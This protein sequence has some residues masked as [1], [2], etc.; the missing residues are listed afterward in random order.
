MKA[1]ERLHA[2]LQTQDG[3][4]KCLKRVIAR[5]KKTPRI[6]RFGGIPL[7]RQKKPAIKDP[8]RTPYVN[9]RSARVERLMKDTCEVC[10]SKAKVHMHHIR[11]LK[12]LHKEGKRELPLWMKIMIYRKRQSIPECM[13][14]HDDIHHNRPRTKRQG[15]RRAG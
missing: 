7:K 5:E 2:T 14:C 9:S 13:V 3:P 4:R 10:G 6:A 1:Q 12:D 15:N 11:H 8:V